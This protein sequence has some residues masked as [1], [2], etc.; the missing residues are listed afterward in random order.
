MTVQEELEWYKTHDQYTGCRNTRLIGE[1]V[2]KLTGSPMVC[3]VVNLDDFNYYNDN[4][5]H[6]YGDRLLG[7]IGQG[8]RDIFGDEAVYSLGGDEFEVFSDGDVETFLRRHDELE[9]ALRNEYEL[10][11][12]RIS[13]TVSTGYVYGTA[14]DVDEVMRMSRMAARQMFEAKRQGKQRCVGH[15][16]NEE[17]FDTTSKSGMRTYRSEELDSLTGNYRIG[18]K[19]GTSSASG[20]NSFGGPYLNTPILMTPDEY[21][22]WS[23]QRSI[24]NYYR[25]KNRET[26]ETS[27][28]SKFDFTDMKFDLGPAEKIFGPGGVQIKTQGSAELKIGGTHKN[29][30]NPSLASNRRKTFSFDFDEKINLSV[31]GKVGDKVNLNINYNTEATMDFDAQ[32]LKLKYDGKEDEIIKLV[33]AG[34][35]SMPSNSNLIHGVSSLFGLRT[36]LQFGKLKLQTVVSQKKSASHSVSSK[37]GTQTTNYEISAV[38][39]EEN[40]HFWLSHYFRENYDRWMKTLPTIASGVTIKRVELWVTNKNASTQNNRNIIAFTDLGEAKH[41]SSPLW[42]SAGNGTHAY[43]RANSLYQHIVQ[44]HPDARDISKVTTELDAIDPDFDGG[45][46]YEKL[47]SARLLSSSEYSLNSALGYVSLNFQLKADEVL[48]VAFE[49]TLNGQTY[50]VGEFASDLTDNTQCLYVK[51][52][53]STTSSPRMGNWPLMMKNIYPLGATSTQ[54]EKFRLDVKYQNDTAGVYQTYLPEARLKSTPL[55]RAMNLDR[56]DNNNRSNSDGQFDYVEGYTI[57]KGRIIFPVAEPFGDH[58]R[59]WIGDDAIADKYCFD[60]LY[61][62]TKTIAKQIAEQNKF[63]LSGRYKGT[64]GAEIDLGA[65]NIAPGSVVVTAGGM[66]LTE[67]VD[68]RVDYSMGMVTILNQSLID[69]N[70]KI[71]AHVESDDTYAMQRKTFLGVNWD[72]EFS[73]NFVLGG[74]FQFLNEQPLTTKVTMGSEPLKNTLWG[75]HMDW[76]KESQWLTNALNAIPLLNFTVPSQISFSADFAQLIAGQNHRVQGAASYMDDFEN[77][78]T[79][80]SLSTPTAWMMSSVPTPI[81]GSKLTNDVRSGYQRALLAWYYIDPIFTRRSSSLPPSHIKGD[82]NQLSD[83]YVREVYERDLYPNKRQ[84]SYSEAASLNVLN[85]AYYPTERGAYNL[86]PDVDSQGRLTQPKQNWGGM[87]RKTDNPDFEAQNFEYI[88]FWLLDPFLYTGDDPSYGGE[89]YIDLGEISEDVLKDGKKFYESGLPIDDN[90]QYYQETIWGRVPTSTSV[91]YAFNNEGGARARQDIGL[92]GLTSTQERTFGIY[93][94]Y[95]NDIQGKVSPEV[96]DSIAADPAG[97]DYHYYRG[98]DFDR[99]QVSIL[100]RYKR[101]NMPEGNSPD[102]ENSPESYETAYKTS[103]DVEDINQDYTLNEYEKYFQYHVSLHP[104]DTLV[105]RNYISD[106]RHITASLRNGEKRT[107]RWFQFRIPLEEYERAEGGI[108]DFTSIR[109]IRMY[110]TGFEKP[111]I[112]RFATLDLVQADWRNYEQALY[113]GKAPAV[114]ATLEVGAVNIE[115]NNEKLPVNY[116][117]P[118]GISRVTDPAQTQLVEENEQALSLIAKNLSPGDARAVFKNCNYDMRQYKHLQLFVHANALANDI[119]DLRNGETSVFLRIGS[120]YKSN[121]YEYEVPLQLTPEGRYDQ[122][123]GADCR[124]VW[125][126]ENMIDIELEKFT[127]L[128]KNRN[129]EKSLGNANYNQEFSEFDKDRPSNKITVMGNP[130]L[131]EVKTIMIGIRNNGRTVKSVEVWTNEMRLQEFSNE[132]GWAAQAALNIQLSDLGSVNVQ[133]HYEKAGFGGIEQTVAER[134]DDNTLDYTITTQLDFGKLLPPKAKVN[135]PFYYSYAKESVKPRYNPLDTDM[136]LSD[137]LDATT[138]KHERDSISD[139]TTKQQTTKNLS[140]TGVKVNIQ[141]LKHPMPYDP[142]NFTFNYS[143]SHTYSSGE[144][145]V[146]EH[147]K[148]WRGGM[149]YSWTPNWKAWEPFK[150]IKSKSKWLELIKAQNFSFA[151]QSLTF[152]TDIVRT[153]YEIQERD[154]ENLESPAAIPVRWTPSFLWNREFNL[155]WDF[156]KA[157]HFTFQSGTHAEIEEPYT[158]VNKDLYF[159]RYSAWKDSV[160]HSIKGFGTPLDYSQSA[161]LSY[162][163]PFEKIPLTDWIQADGSYQ[164]QYS[165]KRGA[166]LEDGS[167]LGNTINTQRSVNLNGRLNLET[168][169]N[170]SKFLADANKRFTASTIK[171][172]GK[173]KD[174]A[175][176][177]EKEAKQKEEDAAAK[178]RAEAEKKAAEGDSTALKAL[179]AENL[180]AQ[181]N[182]KGKSAQ[183]EKEFKGFAG[184]VVLNGD[185]AVEVKHGQKSRR[186]RVTAKD[187]NGKNY[188]IKYKRVDENTI[189]ILPPKELR[190]IQKEREKAEKKARKKRGEQPDS[191]IAASDSISAATDSIGASKNDVAATDSL[192]AKDSTDNQSPFLRRLVSRTERNKARRAAREKAATPAATAETQSFDSLTNKKLRVNVIALPKVEDKGWYQWAQAGA[193]FLMMLRNVSVSYRNTYALGL[194][195]FMP[196]VGDMLGQR[197]M[198]GLMSPGVDFAFG[199]IGDSYIDRAQENHWLLNNDSASYPASS[200]GMEDLQ[201]KATLEPLPDLKIDV[202][203]S[204][205]TNK[206]KSI[207]YMYAGSPTTQTG[208]FNMTTISIATA[209][210]SRGNAANG[211]TSDP[212]TQFQQYLDVMQQRVEQQYIGTQYPKG[213]GNTGTFDPANGTVNK[214]SSDVMVPAFLAAYTG[215]SAASTPLDIFPALTRVL[216]NW[217]LSYKGLSNLPWV[218]DHLKNVTLTHAYKSIYSVGSYNTYSSWVEYMHGSNLGYVENTT[219]GGYI[220]SSMYD[221]STVSINEGFTPLIGLNVTLENNMTLKAEYRKTRVLTLSM[222]SAQINEASSSDF[223]FGWGYKIDDFKIGSLFSSKSSSQRASAKNNRNSRNNRAGNDDEEGNNRNNRNNTSNTRTSNRNNFAHALNLRFDFSIRNQDA[224]TRNIQTNLSEATSGNSALKASFAADYSMSRWVTLSL[225]YDLQR[226]EPLLSSSAYPTITQ[227]FGFNL[228]LTLTR[229]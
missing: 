227:D 169:Y 204:R 94:Q 36:D 212:F 181:G 229:Q 207:Q 206:T 90:P 72:Y 124:A 19:L 119:T 22:Q 194:P 59:Q 183:K 83:S 135:V 92:N 140:L 136:E 208:N 45:K 93:Q 170:H 168:L 57:S 175:K 113:S 100:D 86:N 21:Q 68:Y 146:Y 182:A 196:N 84:N 138:S 105:G 97:D 1:R 38:D 82:V 190:K 173:K 51:A 121:F 122:Y 11:G 85:L 56:L 209:F 163:V 33:E 191:L 159:D 131:G 224:I 60:A 143:H 4:F 213:V 2:S 149:N 220:P 144:T 39:Y 6:S 139:L 134:S 156:T 70:Q 52:L 180:K 5:G 123:S 54:R 95:L 8:I 141:T 166:E 222:T 225:Y 165:W 89:L 77:T 3:A 118:P 130:T 193:R 178:K 217:S 158:P 215:R 199:L 63:Q 10:E 40:R 200:N 219:T 87:M 96:F 20:K 218:R 24:R 67:N 28:K 177:K 203:A 14:Q 192:A 228:K 98:T 145:T 187:E 108:T 75:L 137:A 32:Q 74:T 189:K 46:D 109:F 47:Q 81:E 88:E 179:N 155:R 172:E 221:I 202:N 27:G 17:E 214:Y 164:A 64:N 101:I 80:W 126:E 128:K 151:P 142:A 48:A 25:Q 7:L 43:N 76:K 66:T 61:D 132:G 167:T 152:N 37:G 44:N 31:T 223:V 65:T 107:E 9:H 50:Q 103:P 13:L 35:I 125:P 186:I 205:T 147:E 188:T 15:A 41:I 226:N 114:N 116:V 197:K 110:L 71:D 154:M 34:N 211:Y 18:M 29:V 99:Q 58:L 111:V 115:E 129:R 30:K 127:A 216:P 112:L 26:Y 133:G 171:S 78:K 117:L 53:K 195:G 12:R 210:K 62:S 162:K 157:L 174:Q 73:K 176:K 184:E 106:V 201:I 148:S 161:Q 69:S 49:Y 150:N 185:S 23:L 102:T 91:T 16:Y 160:I 198:G 153:Y 79:R 104:S 120:D 42:A 55:L